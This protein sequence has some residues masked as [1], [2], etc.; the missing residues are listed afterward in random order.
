M[1]TRIAEIL[2]FN[3]CLTRDVPDPDQINDRD[4]IDFFNFDHQCVVLK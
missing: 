1:A 3:K 2:Q 4:Q